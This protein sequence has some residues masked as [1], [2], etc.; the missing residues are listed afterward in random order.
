MKSRDQLLWAAALFLLL[1]L[2]CRSESRGFALPEG[3]PETGKAVFVELKCNACH[4]IADIEQLAGADEFNIPL[5]GKTTKVKT[6]GELV[7]SV[8][9]PSHEISYAYFDNVTDTTGVSHMKV[10]NEEMTVQ[11]LI[12]LAAFLQSEYEYAPP[13][14]A[15]HYPPF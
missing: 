15:Y 4:T 6:Y 8:I 2:G 9:H 3:D 12:D 10:Y 5:G 11:E 14:N 7:A 1:G 13:V